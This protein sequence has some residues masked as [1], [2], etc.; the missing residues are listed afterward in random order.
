MKTLLAA[1]AVAGFAASSVSAQVRDMQFDVNSL[2]FQAFAGPNGTGGAVPFGGLTHTGSLVLQD[3]AALSVLND[4][5]I[6]TGGPGNPFVSQAFSGSLT[7]ANVTINLNGGSVTG[8]SLMLQ[9]GGSDTY[10][11]TI[12]NVGAVSTYVGGGFKIEGL[13][14][15]GTVTDAS[16]GGV[17]IPDFFA[18]SGSL[19][20]S[21]LNFRIIPDANGA[22]NA[23]IDIFTT[24]PAPGTLAVAGLGALAVARR[25]RR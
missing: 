18:S 2:V 3:Q 1:A 7:D 22:G 17:S 25:R 11:A 14:S 12:G 5:A 15:G 9:L 21:F 19:T 24:V 20:G 13:T 8:G 16:F 23:D 4:I 6:R 10:A